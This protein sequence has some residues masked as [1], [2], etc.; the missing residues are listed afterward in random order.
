MVGKGSGRGER[1]EG[2]VL[3]VAT[4]PYVEGKVCL[5]ETHAGAGW[6]SILDGN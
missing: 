1:R 2:K 6:T 3:V 4:D 5:T